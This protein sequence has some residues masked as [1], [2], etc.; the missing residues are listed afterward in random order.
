MSVVPRCRD[1]LGTIFT[2]RLV[3]SAKSPGLFSTCM[4]LTWVE[5]QDRRACEQALCAF[6]GVHGQGRRR[7]RLELSGCDIPAIHFSQGLQVSQDIPK[8]CTEHV[9]R[10]VVNVPGQIRSDRHVKFEAGAG[11]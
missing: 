9:S 6:L 3:C 11:C 2:G 1:C 10:V 7:G 4:R 5:L 8:A